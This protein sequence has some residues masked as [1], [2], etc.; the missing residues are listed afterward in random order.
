M[1]LSLVR[2]EMLCECVWFINLIESIYCLINDMVF[3]GMDGD[4]VIA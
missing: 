1:D 4:V 2:V 3:G